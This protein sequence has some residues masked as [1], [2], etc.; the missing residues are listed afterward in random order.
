M[1]ITKAV[2][3]AA[4]RRQRTL[5][6]Q[7]LIDS[8]GVEK[9]VLT[10]VIEE[11]LR[12]GIDEICIVVCP[13]DETAYAEAAS[14]YAGRLTFVPQVQPRGHGHAIYCAHDFLGQAPFL[15][16]VGDHLYVAQGATG[17]AQDLVRVAES[18]NCTVSAVQPSHERLLPYYGCVGG[19]RVA[20][21]AGLYE[22]DTVLEKP[23]PTEAEQYLVV[24][25]LRAGHYLCF[26]GMHVLSPTAMSILGECVAAS[27][28]DDDITLTMALAELI[29]RERYLAFESRGRRYDIGVKYGVFMAQ[30]AL[31]LS[32]QDRE[33][34]LTRLLALL[35]QREIDREDPHV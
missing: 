11:T 15:H 34:V 25:G 14:H 13:G 32:G 28:P 12:A 30:A 18:Q 10:I 2:I 9:P 23:T 7:T 4:S 16:L 33:E 22:I 31:A 5:P 17:C 27:G 8:D 6:L 24:P 21:A 26:F 19:K 29:R 20:G 3:T 35:A 1:K